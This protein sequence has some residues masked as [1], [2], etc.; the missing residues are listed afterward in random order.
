MNE[1]ERQWAQEVISALEA[2]TTIGQRS[3]RPGDGLNYANHDRLVAEGR[4]LLAPHDPMAAPTNGAEVV[5]QGPEDPLGLLV[6]MATWLRLEHG[7]SKAAADLMAAAAALSAE[8]A[9]RLPRCDRCGG[10]QERPGA[11]IF[12]PPD[13]QGKVT[14]THIC[15][16]CQEE[17]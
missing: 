9:G 2:A 12:G 7:E 17:P 16:D 1:Q 13:V 3:C 4:A 11:L 8:R 10:A 14:K 5:V 6:G 15:V